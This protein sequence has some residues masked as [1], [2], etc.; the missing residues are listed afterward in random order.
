[1]KWVESSIEYMQVPYDFAFKESEFFASS[2][3]RLLAP[4]QNSLW[5]SVLLL[6][7][8]AIATVFLT[9]RLSLQKRHFIIGGRLNRTPLL[10]LTNMLLGGPIANRQ[11]LRN[12]QYLKSFTCFL[13][14]MWLLVWLILQN[15]YHGALY[16]YFQDQRLPSPL[17]HIRK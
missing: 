12:N 2:L 9:K 13:L 6:F 14:A 5:Y 3:S 4:F 15:A 16:E 17:I 8:C 11:I 7:F 10:S 1:M